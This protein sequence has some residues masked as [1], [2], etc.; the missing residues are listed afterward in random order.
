V[1]PTCLSSQ[2]TG[3]THTR[4]SHQEENGHASNCRWSTHQQGSGSLGTK[5]GKQ[6]VTMV[7]F[8]KPR[9][10]IWSG[11][12]GSKQDLNNTNIISQKTFIFPNGCTRKATEKMLLKHNLQIAAQEMNIVPSLHLALVSIPKLADAGYTI[13]LTKDGTAIYNDNTKAITASN[14]PILE[15]N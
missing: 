15:S 3:G 11:P 14:P 5:I 4:K 13:V 7:C 8:P 12:G 10:N 2:R 9:S 1:V 6:K